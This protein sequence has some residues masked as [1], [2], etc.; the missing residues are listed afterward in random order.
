MKLCSLE[1][2]HKNLTISFTR[3]PLTKKGKHLVHCVVPSDETLSAIFNIGIMHCICDEYRHTPRILIKACEKAT[4]DDEKS[5]N[6][7]FANEFV[8]A[9]KDQGV[10]DKMLSLLFVVFFPSS[11]T[12]SKLRNIN[13]YDGNPNTKYYL[14]SGCHYL[15]YKHAEMFETKAV[16]NKTHADYYTDCMYSVWPKCVHLPIPATEYSFLDPFESFKEGDK[17]THDNQS[18]LMAPKDGFLVHGTSGGFFFIFYHK[19]RP[20]IRWEVL[21][22]LPWPEDKDLL[23]FRDNRLQKSTALRREIPLNTPNIII[24]LKSKR[25]RSISFVNLKNGI[26]TFFDLSNYSFVQSTSFSSALEEEYPGVDLHMITRLGS[27]TRVLPLHNPFVLIP[28]Y[29]I[30][31]LRYDPATFTLVERIFF[32]NYSTIITRIED[33]GLTHCPMLSF[34]VL[35]S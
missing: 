14:E 10:A 20:P 24:K 30:I 16:Q 8:T 11:A 7:R 19:R 17:L 3:V 31:A 13:Q 26:K 15:A 18:P 5:T 4:L 34:D 35:A 27:S 1:V 28:P 21:A 33:E 22:R 2:C 6:H 29:T 25:Q 23:A 9:W 32:T 12:S